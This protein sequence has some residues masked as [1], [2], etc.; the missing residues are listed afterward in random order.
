MKKLLLLS[1]LLIGCNDSNHGD[2]SIFNDPTPE[3]FA[4]WVAIDSAYYK[5]VLPL[6]DIHKKYSALNPYGSNPWKNSR[7]HLE[8][9][10]LTWR[11]YL[12]NEAMKDEI[13][14]EI[15]FIN[16]EQYSEALKKYR[17]EMDTFGRYEKMINDIVGWK[18]GN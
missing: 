6:V 14:D 3:Q 11:G 10:D 16:E 7:F 5:Q 18:V 2:L 15:E 4:E 13:F 12:E 1:L 8:Y 17:K 9:S